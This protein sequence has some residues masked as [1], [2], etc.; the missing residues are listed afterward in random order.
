MARKGIRY[1][2]CPHCEASFPLAVPKTTI[3]WHRARPDSMLPCP[4][5]GQPGER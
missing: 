4:R 2:L 1:Y 3:P 5:A